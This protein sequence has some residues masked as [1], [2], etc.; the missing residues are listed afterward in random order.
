[1]CYLKYELASVPFSSSTSQQSSVDY[2]LIIK[3]LFETCKLKK[4]TFFIISK[5]YKKQVKVT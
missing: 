1:M 2:V 3:T 5:M 4:V